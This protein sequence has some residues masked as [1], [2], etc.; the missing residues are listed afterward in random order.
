[1]KPSIKCLLYCLLAINTTIV[2]QVPYLN[3]LPNGPN[4]KAMVYERVGLAEISLKY[5]RP[6]VNGR[7]GA[8]WGKLVHTGF[9]NQG[10]GTN[11]PAPWRAGANENTVFETSHDITVEGKTLPKGKYGFFVAY[12]P[13]SCIVIFSKKSDGWGSYF[14]D[15]ADDVLR[16]TV[17][18]KSTNTSVEWLRYNFYNETEAAATLVLEWEKL[19]IPIRIE[20]NYVKDQ[21]DAISSELRMPAGFTWEALTN[22]AGWCLSRNYQLD[23]ALVWAKLSSDPNSWG[24]D[25]SFK[26]INTTASILK[27]LCRKEEAESEMKRAVNFGTVTEI[28]QYA[29]QLLSEKKT[30][31]A[32][33]IFEINYKKFPDQFTTLIGMTRGLSASGQY[34]KALVFAEKALAIAPDPQNK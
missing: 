28:H 14:Y 4:K 30:A 32:L 8:V 9:V 18:P 26:A 24:G 15:E 23:Q 11:K 13:E 7:E 29:R 3:S 12:Q 27:A 10:F 5:Y 17:V 31:E 22:A 6:A 2:A 25:H 20:T 1:M 16:V 21:F 34:K 33:A 19:Q